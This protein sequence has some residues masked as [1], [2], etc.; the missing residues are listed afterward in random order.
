MRINGQGMWY[1]FQRTKMQTEIWWV[2]LKE[3]DHT[4]VL[5]LHGKVYY[6]NSIIV[7]ALDFI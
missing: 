4:K 1:I 7:C 5:G 6:K 2:V 3:K